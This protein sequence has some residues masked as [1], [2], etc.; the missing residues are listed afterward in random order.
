[1]KNAAR[2]AFGPLLLLAAVLVFY[3][4]ACTHG[5]DKAKSRRAE[6]V[7]KAVTRYGELNAKGYLIQAKLHTDWD[8]SKHAWHTR[9]TFL[10]YS[11]HFDV[12]VDPAGLTVVEEILTNGDGKK[13]ASLD[14][15]LPADW[16]R[17]RK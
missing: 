3:S 15:I 1:M 14:E 5:F 11:G 2:S 16:P 13:C 7:E 12:W 6:S 8:E 17:S 10:T 9:V 4:S